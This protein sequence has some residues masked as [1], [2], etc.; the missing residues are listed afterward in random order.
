[1]KS[2]WF[3]W[4]LKDLDEFIVET[5]KGLQNPAKEGDYTGLVQLMGN[6]MAVKDRQ[7]VTD[8]MFDPLRETIDLLKLYDHE[9]PDEVYLQLQVIG[10]HDGLRPVTLSSS[11]HFQPSAD[12][13]FPQMDWNVSKSAFSTE[14][15]MRFRNE[16]LRYITFITTE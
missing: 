8:D 12:W 2:V 9:M 13:T 4:S 1:M 3:V 6:V 14:K 10:F 11:H 15:S 16:L 5:D 7:T